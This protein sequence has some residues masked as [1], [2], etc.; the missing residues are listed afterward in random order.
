MLYVNEQ[1]CGDV[2]DLDGPSC[3]VARGRKILCTCTYDR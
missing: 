3:H 1:E 2:S